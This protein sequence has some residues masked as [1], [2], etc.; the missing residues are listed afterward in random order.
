MDRPAAN[1]TSFSTQRL[2]SARWISPYQSSQRVLF[3][4]CQVVP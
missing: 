2:S 4:S 3:I 1:T